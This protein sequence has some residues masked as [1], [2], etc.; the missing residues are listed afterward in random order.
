M[1]ELAIHANVIAAEIGLRS[2]L[3]HRL[4]VHLDAALE[5]DLLGGAAAGDSS[6]RQYLL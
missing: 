6:L 2:K 5:D 4:A 3:R 1:Q